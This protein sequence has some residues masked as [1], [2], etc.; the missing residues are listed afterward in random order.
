MIYCIA[1]SLACPTENTTGL[2]AAL[3]TCPRSLAKAKT[4]QS[5]E[6]ARKLVS[7]VFLRTPDDMNCPRTTISWPVWK[8]VPAVYKTCWMNQ[9]TIVDGGHTFKVEWKAEPSN[10]KSEKDF[11]R[12]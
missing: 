6:I 3:D 1:G 9:K 4:G 5:F 7:C 2:E 11:S 12:S 10:E 8:V